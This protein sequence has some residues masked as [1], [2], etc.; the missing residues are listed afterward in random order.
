MKKY[1]IFLIM[2]SLAV[3]WTACENWTSS[4]DPLIDKVED[5]RLNTEDAMSFLMTG[6]KARFAD[7]VDD[8]FVCA[9]LLSDQMVFDPNVPFATY[10]TYNELETGIVRYDNNSVDAP[11]DDLGELRFFAD[12]LIER[13]AGITFVDADLEALVTYTGKFYGAYARFLYAAYFGLT[14]TQGGATIDAGPFIASAQLYADAV[15]LFEEAIASTSDAAE[16]RLINSLIARI[17]LYQ[18]NFAKAKEYADKGMVDGDDVFQ[19]EY[20]PEADNFYRQ[21][22]G[23]GR[24]QAVLDDRFFDYVKADPA[25]AVR[26]EFDS[27][28]ANDETRYFYYQTKYPAFASPMPMMTWQENALML[29]ECAL[30]GQGGDAAALVNAVR[31]S[32][33]LDALA[34]VDKAA[35]Q[36]ERDKELMCQGNRLPDQRR[37][38]IWHLGAGT[39]QYL[40]LTESEHNANENLEDV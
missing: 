29:A 40:P 33:G 31:A 15:T 22:A 21:Q 24:Q 16:I 10:P 12:N 6:I 13:A 19:S 28:L 32:H 26:V 7:T 3:T 27:V 4:V 18:N 11:F 23:A 30:E 1:F 36:V 8:L 25:E 35:V 34:A 37:W 39:W 5:E 20:T 2:L 38:G 14:Q 17:Y 9:D